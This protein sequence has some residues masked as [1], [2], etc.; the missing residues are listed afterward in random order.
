MDYTYIY[1]IINIS[2]TII[3]S[4]GDFSR[5]APRSP[6]LILYFL[7]CLIHAHSFIYN[8]YIDYRHTANS[9]LNFLLNS[10]L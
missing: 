6:L 4:F 7:T 2:K 9:R 3:P 8:I 5:L 10:R 1:R